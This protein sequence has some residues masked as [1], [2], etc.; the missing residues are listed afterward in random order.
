MWVLAQNDHINSERLS[1]A[2]D[3]FVYSSNNN[4]YEFCSCEQ[5]SAAKLRQLYTKGQLEC[6]ALR[7]R[8]RLLRQQHREEQEEIK[9]LQENLTQIGVKVQKT[10]RDDIS[11]S[12]STKRTEA[13]KNVRSSNGDDDYEKLLYEVKKMKRDIRITRTDLSMITNDELEAPQST[14]KLTGNNI[15]S[16]LLDDKNYPPKKA[17]SNDGKILGVIN[18]R[19]KY[20]SR[21]INGSSIDMNP[22]SESDVVVYKEEFL[23]TEFLFE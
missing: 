21:T 7:K 19:Y 22:D 2:E 16:G 3:T 9:K 8:L 12:R 15:I 14:P 17:R 6:N 11:E 1:G 20:T 13:E 23:D 4:L 10:C 5:P 18:D